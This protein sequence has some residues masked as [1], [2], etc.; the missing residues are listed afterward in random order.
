MI[1]YQYQIKNDWD[2]YIANMLNQIYNTVD[3][4]LFL[5]KFLEFSSE[6]SDR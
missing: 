6:I 5:S 4:L 2:L 3:N 1:Q